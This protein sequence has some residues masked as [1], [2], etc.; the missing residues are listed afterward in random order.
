MINPLEFG[1]GI[2]VLVY[3]YDN[4]NNSVLDISWETRITYSYLSKIIEVLGKKG[5]ISSKKEGRRLI[6]NLTKNGKEIAKR[7]IEINKILKR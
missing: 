3:L 5:L 6:I 4:E 1:K 2:E 7:F